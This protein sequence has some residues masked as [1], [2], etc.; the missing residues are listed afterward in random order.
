[1]HS[2]KQFRGTMKNKNICKFPIA[3]LDTRSLY[4]TCFVRETN[5]ETMGKEKRLTENRT[6]LCTDGSGIAVISGEK[7]P[8][9]RGTL[10]FSMAGETF[11]IESHSGLEYI[12]IDFYGS[13]SSELFRRFDITPLSRK[14]KGFE[15]L[16]PLWQES[17]YQSMEEN[18]DL[19]GES[20]LLFTFSRLY[21]GSSADRGLIGKIIEITEDN[22]TDSELSITSLSKTLSYHPKYL[23][24]LFKTKTGVGYSEYLRSVRLKYATS[25]FDRGLDSVKSVSLLSGFSDPFYFSNVFK[26]NIGISPKEYIDAAK[27]TNK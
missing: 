7:H 1:M 26:K 14:H 10:L 25:L 11:E 9:E 27:S 3:S 2:S 13:R 19:T 5:S 23:S 17:L 4:V 6:L 12:Y 21:S 22:F 24:H 16:I 18:L 8:I 20:L 15:G